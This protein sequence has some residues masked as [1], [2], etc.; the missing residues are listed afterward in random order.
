MI[1]DQIDHQSKIPDKSIAI[2]EMIKHQVDGQSKIADKPI[3]IGEM[4]KVSDFIVDNLAKQQ[5]DD[6]LSSRQTKVTNGEYGETLD[7]TSCFEDETIIIDKLKVHS[8]EKPKFHSRNTKD[9]DL[10]QHTVEDQGIKEIGTGDGVNTRKR[11]A[12]HL[13][14]HNACEK[15]N[16]KVN[17]VAK[18][19]DTVVTAKIKHKAYQNL[20]DSD[21][22]Y[23]RIVNSPDTSDEDEKYKRIREEYR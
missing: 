15:K 10:L 17:S 12:T 1:K 18:H 22:G 3:T 2:G 13:D 6:A 7:T 23:S 8:Y 5:I 9:N 16:M 14:F 11:R 21:S 19:V 20:G 4:I